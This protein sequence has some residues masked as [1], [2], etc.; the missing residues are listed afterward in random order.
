MVSLGLG[1]AFSLSRGFSCRSAL[2][3]ELL[4]PSSHRLLG[5]AFGLGGL[6]G[7]LQQTFGHWVSHEAGQQF[8]AADGVIVGGDRILN[9]FRI[10]VGVDDGDN[11][12]AQLVGF[13][14][15]QSFGYRPAA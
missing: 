14:D 4:F 9:G 12:N 1:F 7:T 5:F 8:D 6:A 2:G 3:E 11:R 13:L 10:G 15:G